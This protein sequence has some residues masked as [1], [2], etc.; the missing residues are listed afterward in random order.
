M[1]L[2]RL[3][4]HRPRVHPLLPVGVVAVDDLQSD[5][6]A[7]R[8]PVAHT[9]GYRDAVVL[10]LHPAAASVAQLAARQIAIERL[11]IQRQSGRQAFEDA[12]EAGAVRLAG[13]DEAEG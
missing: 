3:R 5:R 2:L 6:A 12:G 11:A 13:R 1:Y 7:E 9:P 4:L 8:A 10:D